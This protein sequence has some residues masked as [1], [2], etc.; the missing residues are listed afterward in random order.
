MK[1]KGEISDVSRAGLSVCSGILILA[2]D[3]GGFGR[4]SKGRQGDSFA[5]THAELETHSKTDKLD[6][7]ERGFLVGSVHVKSIVQY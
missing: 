2:V 6:L 7:D 5:P 4:R 3:V 1:P